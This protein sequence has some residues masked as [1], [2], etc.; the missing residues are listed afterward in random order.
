MSEEAWVT[1]ATNDAYS[2]GALTLGQS[3]RRSG[4]TRKLHCLITP[5]VSGGMREHLEG[6]FDVVS[7]VDLLDSGDQENLRLIGRPDLGITFTKLHCWRLTRYSK[8]VF[9]DADTLV[10][11][12]SDELFQHEE[13]SAAPDVGWPDIFNTGV[14]V[15]RPSLD[16]YRALLSL[17][18]SEG[19]FDGGDQGLLNAYFSDW[20]SKD[21]SFRL[22]FTYNMS[23]GAAYTYAAAFKRFGAQ[24]KIVHFLGSV[25]PWHHSYGPSGL[26]FN[27][28]SFHQLEHVAYW[29]RIFT[30][31]VQGHLKAEYLPGGLFVAGP[32]DAERQ[33]AWEAGHPDY[34]GRDAFENIQR[35]LDE[36][37]K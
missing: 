9:M 10:L 11:Q 23:S 37:M 19:S 27:G 18:L 4:T 20:R 12:N 5:G 30:E 22:P 28:G 26:Q 34:L 24:V 31:N 17:A 35:A 1:L 3:L 33:R 16:T 13:L 25:K 6:V 36:A 15:F 29:W 21:V 2:L 32:S 8:C 14:F 7:V